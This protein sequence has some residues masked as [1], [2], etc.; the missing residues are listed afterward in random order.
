MILDLLLYFFAGYGV[1]TLIAQVIS[2]I[3]L[4]RARKK[5]NKEFVKLFKNDDREF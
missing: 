2:S 5:M 3:K 4:R 1:G